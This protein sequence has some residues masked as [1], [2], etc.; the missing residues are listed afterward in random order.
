MFLSSLSIKRP[1]TISMGLVVFLL[2]GGLSYFSLTLNMM[3]DVE[4]GFVTVQTIYPGAG[5]KEVETQITEKIEDVVATISQI[6][7]LDSYSM[8]SVS[9]VMLQF[10]ISKDPDIANQEVKDKIN[11]ILNDLPDDAQTPIV[12]KFDMGALPVVDLIFSGSSISQKEMYE[13]ADNFLKERLSQVEGVARVN[14][15]GGIEREIRVELENRVVYENAISLLQLNQVL[16]AWNMDMPGGRFIEDDQEYSVRLQ[17]RFNELD[18]LN[19]VEVPTAGG[20]KRLGTLADITDSGADVRKRTS[21]FQTDQN[22]RHDDVILLSITKSSDGNTVELARNI[23]K[24]V[25]KLADELPAGCDL[26]IVQD[27]SIFIEA[28]VE[29][30]LSNIMLGVLL[31]GL[32]LLFFLHDLR[33]TIIVSLAMPMSI[34]STFLLIETSGFT[35][36]IM[37]LMGLSTSVGILVANSVVVLENIF[38]YKG[39]GYNKKEAADK[40]TSDTAIAVIASTMTNIVVFLPIAFMGGM[41][42]QI[43]SEFALTVTYATIFS[44]IISFT[45]TPMLASLIL[46]DKDTKTH[47]VG[48]FL[49][50][51]FKSWENFYRRIL[52]SVI[53][54][55][56]TSLLTIVSA[57]LLFFASFFIASKIGF[58]FFPMLD[59]GNISMEVELP[60]GYNLDETA[61]TLLAI[62]DEISGY[63]E[64]KHIITTLGSTNEL[65]IGPNLAKMAVKLVDADHRELSSVKVTEK[66]IENLSKIPNAKIRIAAVNAAGGQEAPIQFYLKGQNV[67]QLETYKDQ[68]LTHIKNVHGLINLNTS[69]RPGAPEITILPDR[70]KVSDAGLTV[71]DLALTMR[72]AVEGMVTSYFKDGSEEYDIRVTMKDEDVNSL[73]KLENLTVVGPLGPQRLGNLA[74][75]EYTSGYSKILHKDK[76]KTIQFT[77]YTSHDVPLGDVVNSIRANTSDME[78]MEG[79]SLDWGGEAEMMEETAADMLRTFIIAIVLTYMLLAAI[80]ES[81]TQPL[82][83]LGTVPMALIGVFAALFITGKSMNLISMMSIIM[84]LGIVVNN[85]ILLLDYTNNLRREGQKVS[86]ALLKACPTKLKPILMASI[87]IILGMMP[88]ALGIGSAGKEFRQPMAIVSIGGLI[89]S[90]ILALIVIPAIY[91]FASIRR[92]KKEVSA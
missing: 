35:L 88:M 1:I 22:I 62:E 52:G 70:K 59:E 55:R 24:L 78:M 7:K 36:N 15:T 38:R 65:D 8:E 40:G 86:E 71:M 18:Q 51:I 56:F 44:L 16:A 2:F 43:F 17:G 47:P 54:N 21:F 68:V 10:E 75:L 48:N 73:D 46:P 5:P 81:L 60:Q 61:E 67:D 85:A 14:T 64:V 50:R 87:A 28:S 91:H 63:P 25:P 34:I 27:A 39:L 11:T 12:E 29:D 45:L 33:S 74:E 66:F 26:D 92:S 82:M 23:A 37:T 57:F 41:V 4:F 90:T 3:P 89:V 6:D 76:S 79:Y 84:L 77:A 58:E 20:M 19:K 31:T 83:I 42:G 49:D 30:T 53:K 9:F 69:S 32:V 72:T 80:L 13:I